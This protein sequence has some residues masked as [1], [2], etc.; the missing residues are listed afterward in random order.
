MK[1]PYSITI[2]RHGASTYNVLRMLKEQDSLYQT[3]RQAF[4]K[5]HTSEETRRLA[6]IVKWKFRLDT[7]DYDTPLTN[8][9]RAQAAITGFELSKD[10]TCPDIIFV[11]PYIRTR[12]T[13]EKM[14]DQWPEL[15]GS[16]VFFDERIREKEH[17]LYLLYNDWRVFQ[18]FHPEQ[19][20]LRHLMGPYW[21]QYPQ[22]ESI[23]QVRDR[24]RSFTEMLIRE[25]SGMRVLVIT[26]HLT[27]LSIRANL[28]RLSPEQFIHLDENEKPINC[29]VTTYRGD[30]LAGPK[31]K[32]QLHSYNKQLWK[33]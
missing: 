22:G 29:G 1:W 12:E 32:L 26:H 6:T 7:S 30:P 13:F 5:D 19:K 33:E 14:K 21:Y 15:A 2:V 4:D 8:N 25:C 20:A 3:F 9:G 11:S 31:G 27:I 16:K 23:S 24:L 10:F 18:T 28:E 17:G